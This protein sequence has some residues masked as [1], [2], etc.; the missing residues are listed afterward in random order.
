MT[1]QIEAHV[2]EQAS[3][4]AALVAGTGAIPTCGDGAIDAAGEHCDGAA[5]DGFTCAS[6]G[7]YGSLACTSGCDLDLSACTSCP[8]PGLQYG[9]GCWVLGALAATCDAACAALA[10]TYDDATSIIAGSSG[11]DTNCVALLGAT[12]APGG[13]LDNAGGGCAGAALGCAVLPEYG[14]RARCGTPATTSSSSFV[15][16]RRMCACHG[17]GGLGREPFASGGWDA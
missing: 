17:R 8:A 14:F 13:A 1:A 10:M 7:L 3:D 4:T 15:D 16:A 5:L 6:F 12:G 9:G 11:S 2:S